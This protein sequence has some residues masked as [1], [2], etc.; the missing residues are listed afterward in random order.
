MNI[1]QLSKRIGDG[2]KPISPT[3]GKTGMEQKEKL[4]RL[5]DRDK[6][7]Q[8]KGKRV[9]DSEEVKSLKDENKKLK[10]CVSDAEAQCQQYSDLVAMYRRDKD[11]ALSNIADLTNQLNAARSVKT[12][13]TLVFNSQEGTLKLGQSEQTNVTSEEFKNFIDSICLMFPEMKVSLT[14]DNLN[15]TAQEVNAKIKEDAETVKE[16]EVN[17][18]V[19]DEPE[20]TWTKESLKE[21]VD[22]ATAL[23]AGEGDADVLKA[24]VKP[25]KDD[26]LSAIVDCLCQS[27]GTDK[28][29]V[30]QKTLEAYLQ[31]PADE[32]EIPVTLTKVKDSTVAEAAEALNKFLDDWET[33]PLNKLDVKGLPEGLSSIVS[34]LQKRGYLEYGE[35][36]KFAQKAKEELEADNQ[37]VPSF[38]LLADSIANS[39]EAFKAIVKAKGI[40]D[41]V[42]G[43]IPGTP[44]K[45]RISDSNKS[46][47]GFS[48]SALVIPAAGKFIICE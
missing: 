17:D 14:V 42:I 6:G 5:F 10:K 37:S 3:M 11:E 8:T 35:Y 40:S 2:A 46:L 44:D 28:Q 20:S 4:Q 27:V 31:G 33:E 26:C 47:H 16:L 39:L 15:G 24:K 29:S 18:A 19:R 13:F 12:P 45:F 25:L 7:S 41:S 43:M 21:I 9:S 23:C 36:D 1:N 22:A 48:R 38:A 30:A 34:A 32:F